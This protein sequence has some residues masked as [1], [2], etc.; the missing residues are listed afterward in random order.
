MN[1][2]QILVSR[3]DGFINNSNFTLVQSPVPEITEGEILIKNEFI[4]LDP[5]MRGWMNEGTTYIKG[6]EL[7]S[8]MRAFAVGKIIA[9]KN[10]NYKLDDAVQGMF[11]VQ[12]Y[13]VTNGKNVT[14]IY[15]DTFPLSWH[16][17]ILG[18]PGLT[19]Y[20]GLLDKAKPI[21]GDTVLISGAA[22][23]VGNLVGQ[24]AKLKG[25][26][27][28]GIAGGK[29]KCDY[30]KQQLNFDEMI[31][32]KSDSVAEKIKLFAPNGVNIF[33][34]NVGGQ[35]LDDALMNLA[36]G[37]RVV[38]CGAISQYNQ[39]SFNGLKNY[40][41]IVSAR[42]TLNGIIV[43]DYF[44]RAPEAIT[45]LSGWLTLDKI[46]YKEHLID[47]IENFCTAL[48]MLYTGENFGKLILK[49]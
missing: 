25:C 40:M 18:M 37:A 42:A 15:A 1:K 43:L 20:F 27:V 14:K 8:V 41:K 38:I 35:M 36:I 26:R 45:D 13:V 12:Q 33:F 21:A 44:D 9:S 16:L 2:Q 39:S 10:S 4:S 32:Y 24:I 23:M 28:I 3:P 11:G 34:D 31:D 30:L 5:A 47:G 19:A 49:I 6:V 22:G 48:Q 17:G 29:I 7:N 46:I